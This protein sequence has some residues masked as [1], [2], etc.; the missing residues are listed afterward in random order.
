MGTDQATAEE[1]FDN[2]V[3]IH[4]EARDYS[5]AFIDLKGRLFTLGEK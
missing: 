4:F 1:M 5:L 2:P 3:I